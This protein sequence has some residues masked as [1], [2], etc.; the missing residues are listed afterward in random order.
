MRQW[1][2]LFNKELLEMWRNYKWVWVPLVFILFGVL[3]PISTHYLPQILEAVGGM[4]EGAVIEIPLPSG[5]E[6]INKTLEQ[7]G[8]LGV[9]ILVLSFMGSVSLEKQSGVAGLILVKPVPFFSYISS[10]WTAAVI[11]TFVSL[12]LGI[13]SSWY[14]TELLVDQVDFMRIIYTSLLFGLWLMVVITIT[15]FMSTLLKGNGG[16][17]FLSLFTIFALSALAGIFPAYLKWNPGMLPGF[18]RS[19]LVSG[20]TGDGLIICLV[21]TISML[22][23]LLLAS[24]YLLKEKELVD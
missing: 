9:L 22:V 23:L 24:S 10:K 3:Q 17:A 4:P 13:L 18:A 5:A 7:Y 14:Y 16:I 1:I 12:F 11:L 6:V 20:E 15:L 8:M 21:S 2:V 19:L